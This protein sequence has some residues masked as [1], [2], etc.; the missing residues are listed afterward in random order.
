MLRTTVLGIA[1]CLLTLTLITINYHYIAAHITEFLF[2]CKKLV[3]HFLTSIWPF[4]FIKSVYSVH[5][6]NRFKLNDRKD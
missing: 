3:Q 4:T 5:K 1:S 2:H 6:I